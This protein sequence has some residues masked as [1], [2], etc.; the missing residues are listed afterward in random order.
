VWVAGKSAA[1]NIGQNYY[2][3]MAMYDDTYGALSFE[4]NVDD[5]W[6][7][8]FSVDTAGAVTVIDTLEHTTGTIS[9]SNLCWID[10]THFAVVWKDDGNT[11][12]TITVFSVDGSFDN[13]TEGD[14]DTIS[15][16]ILTGDADLSI[17]LLSE[18]KVVVAYTDDASDGFV[19]VCTLN[20]SYVWTVHTAD[21]HDTTTGIYQD[22]IRMDD[23][24]FAL[25]YSDSVGD[26][27]AKTFS[28]DGSNNITEINAHEFEVGTAGENSICF[29]DSTH[30]A[31]AYR[32]LSNFGTV[33][34]FSV[35]GS[36]IITEID[37]VTFAGGDMAIR[38]P[39]IITMSSTKLA[40]GYCQE[41][42]TRDFFVEFISM[43]GSFDNLAVIE[44]RASFYGVTS[45]G[46]LYPTIAKTSATQIVASFQGISQDCMV[47][48]IRDVS[49]FPAIESLT[50]T[51]GSGTSTTVNMPSTRPD[52]DLYICVGHKDDDQEFTIPTPAAD[53]WTEI[54]SVSDGTQVRSMAWWWEGASE[55]ASYAI[56]HD[57][58]IT[59]FEIIR[60]SGADTT[61]PI[62]TFHA[63]GSSG[64]NAQVQHNSTTNAKCLILACASVDR[65]GV[66]H[67]PED[68]D[69]PVFY[70]PLTT[71]GAGGANDVGW[72]LAYGGHEASGDPHI[73]TD[74]PNW[75]HGTDEYALIWIAIKTGAVASD[76]AASLS[77]ALTMPTPNLKGRGDID[78]A[79]ASSLDLALTMSASGQSLRNGSAILTFA[80]NQVSD[81]KGRGD[82]GSALGLALTQVATMKGRGDIDA[83]LSFLLN[84]VSDLKGR[85]DMGAALSFAINQVIT[86]QG[87]GQM[88]ATLSLALTQTST[89]KG[90]GD[91]GAALGLAIT[92]LTDLKGR[93]DIASAL[94]IALNQVSLLKGRGDVDA[95]LAVALTVAA[96][97]QALANGSATLSFALTQASALKGRGDIGSSLD[98]V[99]SIL[100]DL[101]GQGNM[102]AALDMVLI[103]AATLKGRGDIGTVLDLVITTVANLEA[104][105]NEDMAAVLDI[106]LS[107][108]SLLKGRGDI[109]SAI[110]FAVNQVAALKGLGGMAAAL[111]LTVNQSAELKG[112]GDMISQ[113]T[114]AINQASTIKG[115]GD[116]AIS[117][118]LALTLSPTVK[119]QGDM[120]AAMTLALNQAVTIKGRG[121]IASAVTVVVDLVSNL[122]GLASGDISAVLP[123]SLN[124][125]SLLKGRGDIGSSLGMAVLQAAALKGDGN[126]QGNLSI[127]I[128][129][130]QR[131]KG[132][133]KIDAALVIS[134]DQLSLLKGSTS[135]GSTLTIDITVDPNLFDF[136]I[137]ETPALACVCEITSEPNFESEVTTTEEGNST[138]GQSINKKSYVT[139]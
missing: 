132:Q 70:T 49:G 131:L 9:N 111:D 2:I 94:D 118:P 53:H 130:S 14:S 107:M 80:L 139:F 18:S 95:A 7:A 89:L 47:A 41:A 5:G 61:T 122:E 52:G 1:I 93:G 11:D 56:T 66:D 54:A 114:L 90:R 46:N 119:G 77:F 22:V 120:A 135:L 92:T 109:D 98:A 35:N 21:E 124:M 4:N 84:Q 102:D 78:A 62:D 17:A 121:D 75:E 29:I 79:G 83:A 101:K 72:G 76:M 128:N 40:V 136:A 85:G 105:S 108:S 134:L 64:A 51:A 100:S 39:D 57:S 87:L 112:R 125:S 34:T 58:E 96:A 19:V 8:T 67:A 42:V 86:M 20:G 45:A 127:D 13:I 91:I 30:F 31:I 103:Q 99:I 110:S 10:A 32:G 88:S 106:V 50:E 38:T 28:I 43:D 81:L 97:G 123:I 82:I 26:G 24:H 115:Q 37:S 68:G 55:P 113:L 137:T 33:K 63:V 44:N 23:T 65:D 15:S 36:W 74:N 71:G 60:I 104:T 12:N 116:M 129:T 27:W 25:A 6:V 117:L 69:W 126:I 133:G 48:T 16:T 59:H 73:G 3:K 138:I